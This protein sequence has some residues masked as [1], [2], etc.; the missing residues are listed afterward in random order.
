M[1]IDSG[2]VMVES[3]IVV[4]DSGVVMVE[5]GIVVVESGFV[6]VESGVETHSSFVYIKVDKSVADSG[7]NTVDSA[8][9]MATES[10]RGK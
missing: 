5:S 9:D 4:V 1:V 10:P 7:L 8:Y 2:V 3:G 6:V